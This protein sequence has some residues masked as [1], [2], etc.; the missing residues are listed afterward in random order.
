MTKYYACRRCLGLK[1]NTEEE[2]VLH[3]C[4]HCG[5]SLTGLTKER[6][7]KL[8]AARD[9]YMEVF[10]AEFNTEAMIGDETI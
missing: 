6:Y 10:Y 3:I 7:D 2:P 9:L 8:D 4:G 1:K 5:W